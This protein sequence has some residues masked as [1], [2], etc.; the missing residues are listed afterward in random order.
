VSPVLPLN[1]ADVDQPEVHL[2]DQR[3]GLQH[4]ALPFARHVTLRDPAQLPVDER[5]E[6]LDCGGIA[7]APV[8][9]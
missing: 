4:V 2:V 7:A 6:L 8:D 1:T 3:R 5:H 9:Q